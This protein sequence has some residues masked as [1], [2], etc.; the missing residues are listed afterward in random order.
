MKRIDKTAQVL[1]VE[2]LATLEATAKA[3]AAYTCKTR[4]DKRPEIADKERDL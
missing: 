4:I 2:D 1:N 3:L